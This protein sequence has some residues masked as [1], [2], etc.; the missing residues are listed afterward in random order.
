MLPNPY[1]H[2]GLRV[3]GVGFAS[4][5]VTAADM[6]F[7]GDPT[8]RMRCAFHVWIVED[9]GTVVLLDSG[10]ET[11]AATH[12]QRITLDIEEALAAINHTLD[13]V[14]VI[15]LSHL[16]YDHC[17]SLSRFPRARIAIQRRELE[18]W[19]GDDVGHRDQR[20][21]SFAPY[22]ED[23][24]ELLRAD[25]VDVLDGDE[26]ISDLTTAVLLPG[27]TPGSQGL[28]IGDYKRP[29]IVL[30]GD[31]AHRY[32]EYRNIRPFPISSDVEEMRV[33]Y[34]RLRDWES[35][36]TEVVPA[37]DDRVRDHFTRRALGDC[38]GYLIDLLEPTGR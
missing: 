14:D 26:R 11:N 17:G 29:I 4:S 18:F 35:E 33:T 27:H 2:D 38:D 7:D 20:E 22:L 12:G 6:F 10:F 25:R 9:G 34:A 19:Y 24:S 21:V 30:T 31:A 1:R 37:H 16:H 36:G 8:E 13:D 28:A 5:E 23:L 15:A 3:W 32:E